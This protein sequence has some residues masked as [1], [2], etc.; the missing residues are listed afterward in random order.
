MRLAA[1][2]LIELL[3]RERAGTFDGFGAP[4]WL[5]SDRVLDK[6]K[7]LLVLAE[8]RAA[9]FKDGSFRR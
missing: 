9:S 8:Q 2:D 1:L 3:A 6:A 4:F 5:H 7:Q